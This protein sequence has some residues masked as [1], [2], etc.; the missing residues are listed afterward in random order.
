MPPVWTPRE[1]PLTPVAVAAVDAAASAL[2]RRLL[3]RDDASLRALRGVAAI[4]R[5]LLVVLGDDL[6]WVDGALY[7]GSPDACPRLLTPTVH[8]PIL[9]EALLE[10]ALRRRFPAAE[11]LLAVL[12][13]DTVV[14]LVD[15][16]PLDRARLLE[17]FPEAA[18]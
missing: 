18:P 7:L 6:P 17:R 9:P 16:A 2:A 12:P 4:D 3:D 1:P 15:A 14:P 10:R 11:G 8:A 5:P 13:P